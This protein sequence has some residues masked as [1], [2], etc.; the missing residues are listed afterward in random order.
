MTGARSNGFGG[1][2][3]A[4]EDEGEIDEIEHG[5]RVGLTDDE[6]EQDQFHERGGDK[7]FKPVFLK[8]LFR[9]DRFGLLFLFYA[10]GANSWLFVLRRFCD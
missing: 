8:G 2:D 10:F 4:E 1:L 6:Q 7:E 3:V 9:C 5:G